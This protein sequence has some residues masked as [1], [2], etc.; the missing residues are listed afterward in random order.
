[1]QD[2]QTMHVINCAKYL[3]HDGLNWVCWHLATGIEVGKQMA[4]RTKLGYHI[5]V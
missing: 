3:G 1:M 4:T 2:I 5:V